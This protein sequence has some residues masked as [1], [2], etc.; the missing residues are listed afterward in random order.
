MTFKLGTFS[1]AGC[2]PFPGIVIG[3]RVISLHAVSSFL[4][5]GQRSLHGSD[6]VLGVLESW[7]HNLPA[8]QEVADALRHG[9]APQLADRA[10]PV[11]SLWV[12]PPL[13]YP[14]NIYCS[15]ANYKKHVVQLIV[16]QESEE[17][18]RMSAHERQVYGQRKMDERA[19][20]GT[21]FFFLKAQSAVAG[22]FADIV[23]PHDAQ[24]P[25]WE[26]ELAAVIGRLARNVERERAL[27]YVAGYTIANDLTRRERVNRR[28]GDMREMGMDWVAAKS[29]PTF[30]P[31]GPYLV[32]A[33]FV[34]DPQNV[35]ITLKLNGEVMQDESTA[36]M[37]FGVARLIE[38]LSSIV[39]LQ[40][41]DVICTGSPAGN[42]AHYRR[43]LR[44]GDVLEG[45]ISGLG[46]QRNV[47]SVER[48]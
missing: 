48:G 30:L 5:H 21:P 3:E 39:A 17:T 43:F 18:Q 36:D 27:D 34:A 24:Q 20:T 8:L 4:A 16:A 6:S 38:H 40:P 11:A 44:P 15:G 42:G 19:R 9:R 28:P 29:A 35:Q 1:A 7:E 37:I 46:T 22:P 23:L 25:D 13:M 10:L 31:L 45:S 32:P 2:P 26:L 47:C 12:G 41:G 14:R 33:M